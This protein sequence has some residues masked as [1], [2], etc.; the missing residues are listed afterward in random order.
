MGVPEDIRFVTMTEA[1]LVTLLRQAQQRIVIAKPAYFV[2]EIEAILETIKSKR[3]SVSLFMEVG[4]ESIRRGL[5]EQKA[6]EQ[7]GSNIALLG[8]Q[9]VPRINAGVV[10]VDDKVAVF[11]PQALDPNRPEDEQMFPDG[12]MGG[13][14]IARQLLDNLRQP[15][16][17]LPL[18]AK[19]HVV[20]FPTPQVMKAPPSEVV[21][22]IQRATQEL[23][24]N[25][26]VDPKELRKV[27]FYRNSFKLVKVT[28]YGIKI[29]NLKISLKPF[30]QL[31]STVNEHLLTSWVLFKPEEVSKMESIALFESKMREVLE[32]FTY[33]AGRFGFI[34]AVTSKKD[35]K[36][37]VRSLEEQY[38][39]FMKGEVTNIEENAFACAQTNQ[40]AGGVALG[41]YLEESRSELQKHMLKVC[42]NDPSFMD[43]VWGDRRLVRLYGKVRNGEA[44]A[45]TEFIEQLIANNLKFPNEQEL[46]SRIQVKLDYYDISDE[47]LT[48]NTDFSDIFD[49]HKEKLSSDDLR[50]LSEGYEKM[51]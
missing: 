35:F 4:T 15:N 48:Q 47:L 25:P 19:S 34:I 27:T 49:K 1:D 37:T 20:P 6:L 12:I 33:D 8:V 26:P 38:T 2:E 7:I 30:N 41:E 36:A 24:D 21:Q 10:V 42:E 44:L 17:Q 45:R 51:R 43:R 14:N 3:V 16:T 11:S 46:I 29:R 28:V 23:T 9:T 50:A 31:L 40:A 32:N 13:K 18:Q 22:Q 39:D 5:G